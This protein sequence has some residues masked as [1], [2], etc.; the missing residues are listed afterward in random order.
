M[1]RRVFYMSFK[2]NKAREIF[3][4]YL[5]TFYF[6]FKRVSLFSTPFINF[7]NYVRIFIV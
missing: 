5:F 6:C 3:I 2:T 1:K 7:E 4:Y